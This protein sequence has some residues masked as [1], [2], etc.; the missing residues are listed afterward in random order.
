MHQKLQAINFCALATYIAYAAYQTSLEGLL[1]EAY[2]KVRG[3]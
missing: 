3:Q 2:L 1:A